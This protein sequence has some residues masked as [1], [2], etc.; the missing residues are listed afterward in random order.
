MVLQQNTQGKHLIS[1]QARQKG[2]CPCHRHRHTDPGLGEVDATAKM[3][4]APG[5]QFVECVFLRSWAPPL[6][7]LSEGLIGTAPAELGSA[8]ASVG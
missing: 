2:V 1:T 4:E 8:H 3:E 6:S 7:S 5:Y